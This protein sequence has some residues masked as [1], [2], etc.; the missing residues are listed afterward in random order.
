MESWGLSGVS[1]TMGERRRYKP[2]FLREWRKHRDMTQ[3]RLAEFIGCSVALVSMIERGERGYD[4]AFLESAAEAL[5]T[6]PDRLLRINPLRPESD[7]TLFEMVRRVPE[8]DR[9][10]I[11]AVIE[12]FL[13]RQDSVP[14]KPTRATSAQRRA[15]AGGEK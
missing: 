10:K 13:P 11:A 6:S 14:V 8:A 3:E 5:R 15:K 1:V 7:D 2:P 9:T 4:Q 12:A